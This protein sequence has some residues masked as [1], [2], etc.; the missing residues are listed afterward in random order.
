LWSRGGIKRK[1]MGVFFNTM[2]GMKKGSKGG[3]EE[4]CI[5]GGQQE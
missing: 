1:I 4:G 5:L 2:V 3:K